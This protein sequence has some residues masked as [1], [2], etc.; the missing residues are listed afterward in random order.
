MFFFMSE[1]KHF[2]L[3]WNVALPMLRQLRS[4][5]SNTTKYIIATQM[6]HM[7]QDND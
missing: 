4:N 3:T 7:K 5:V 2:S 1:K 6:Y